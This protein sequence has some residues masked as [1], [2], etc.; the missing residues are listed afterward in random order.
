MSYRF[1]IEGHTDTVGPAGL[2][3]ALSERRAQAVV[4]FLTA[5]FK[6]DPSRLE[7]I[8][9]GETGLLVRTPPNTPE[10]R[11]RRVQVINLGA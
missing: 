9:M 2:N 4:A 6:L 7:A 3:Q 8:G 1:R 5:T 11:N 10:A